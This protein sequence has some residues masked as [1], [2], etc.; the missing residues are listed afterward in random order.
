MK[1]TRSSLFKM[2]PASQFSFTFH[3][4]SFNLSIIS[5]GLELLPICIIQHIVNEPH[6]VTVLEFFIIF[7]IFYQVCYRR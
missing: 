3:F 6:N 1:H 2:V 7:N 5:T 4:L